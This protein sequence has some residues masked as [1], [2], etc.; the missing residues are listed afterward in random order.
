[1]ILKIHLFKI[2]Y[3]IHRYHKRLVDNIRTH[4]EYYFS[5]EAKNVFKS[6]YTDSY[7]SNK[8]MKNID[9]FIV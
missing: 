7:I 4:I 6:F 9:N 2:L 3:V 1:M 5:D 8:K